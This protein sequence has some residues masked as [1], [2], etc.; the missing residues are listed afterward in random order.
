MAARGLGKGLDSL[1]PDSIGNS[2]TKDSKS[3]NG[4]N[5]SEKGTID[6]FIKIT[7]IEPNREQPRKNFDEDALL[8]LAESIKQHGLIQ[9]ILVQDRKDHYE[10]IAGERRWRAAKLAGLKEV[11]VIIRNFTEQEIV[12]ISLIENIQREDLNPIEEAQAYKRLLNEFNLKQDEVAERVSKSRTAVTNSMRLL[13]LCDEVQQMVI[14]DMLSTGHARAILSVEDPE[15]QFILAQK[16][17]DEK[18]SV[19]DV[20]KYV[21]NL[22]K[23]VK[24]KKE[25]PKNIE[26]IYKDLE[27]KLKQSLG[28]KVAVSSKENGSGKIEIEYYSN[29]ELERLMELLTS[30]KHV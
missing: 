29:E 8:E 26:F 30:V 6:T 4:K 1:I 10:I 16:I 15:E 7:K 19:R 21:K 2:R 22:N 25:E 11:P 13:K 27:E 17:F 5:D 3:Q 23:P 9:P 24:Q 14:N 12:E 28:T 18:L 20:E